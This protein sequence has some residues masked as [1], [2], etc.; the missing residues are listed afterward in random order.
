[1][2]NRPIEESQG[3]GKRYAVANGAAFVDDAAD[4]GGGEGLGGGNLGEIE[5]ES[6]KSEARVYGGWGIGVR[7]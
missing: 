5:G 7:V 2:S 1:M 6:W 4:D 3:L